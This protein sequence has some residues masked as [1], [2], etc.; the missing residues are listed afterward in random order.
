[1]NESSGATESSIL[2]CSSCAAEAGV[3]DDA[4]V[5]GPISGEVSIACE[6]CA[7]QLVGFA[8]RAPDSSYSGMAPGAG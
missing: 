3:A 8:Y 6:H 5:A 4:H 1:M 7:A 2:L